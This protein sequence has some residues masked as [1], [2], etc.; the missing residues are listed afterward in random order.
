M[1]NLL[2]SSFI[3]LFCLS[4][5]LKADE[6]NLD[7]ILKNLNSSDSSQTQLIV[8]KNKYFSIKLPKSYKCSNELFLLK[9]FVR[10]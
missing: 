5:F 8:G 1:K 6:L 10:C 3:L 9:C 4:N 2:K 7:S